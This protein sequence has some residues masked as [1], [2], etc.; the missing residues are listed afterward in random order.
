[1]G[2]GRIAPLFLTLLEDA[3]T[4][5]ENGFR[6]CRSI[7]LLYFVSYARSWRMGRRQGRK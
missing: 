6:L 4:V 1:M 7:A 2:E 5:F 3:G